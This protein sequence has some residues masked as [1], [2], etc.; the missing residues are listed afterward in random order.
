M[1]QNTTQRE[2]ERR[3]RDASGRR[4]ATLSAVLCANK[5]LFKKPFKL[6]LSRLSSS[7]GRRASFGVLEHFERSGVG[8][9]GYKRSRGTHPAA[10]LRLEKVA[11][12]FLF[13]S[14]MDVYPSSLWPLVCGSE[15]SGPASSSKRNPFLLFVS[16]PGPQERAPDIFTLKFLR[17][18]LKTV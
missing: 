8:G 10:T 6:L 15:S 2:T 18:H 16:H 13:R 3:N 1:Q 14:R 12:F 17:S 4:A 11:T 9:G 7:A 5:Q